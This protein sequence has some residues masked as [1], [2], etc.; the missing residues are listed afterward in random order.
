MN[1]RLLFSAICLAC[2]VIGSLV[3]QQQAG[4]AVEP[5]QSVSRMTLVD[6]TNKVESRALNYIFLS[7]LDAESVK[8]KEEDAAMLGVHVRNADATLRNHLGIRGEFGLV[9]EHVVEGS[10]AENSKLRVHDVLL[11]YDGQ[12][13]ANQDQFEKLI[14]RNRPGDKVEVEYLR[15]GKTQSKIVALT[16]RKVT[17]LDWTMNASQSCPQTLKFG[18]DMSHEKFKMLDCA[19]CH[20]SVTNDP[21]K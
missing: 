6:D 15:L 5:Q 21:R 1:Y 14:A 17:D 10:A 13:L 19:A 11:K 16:K 4:T 20:V 3:A 9:I 2:L 12:I 7:E 18:K 8:S